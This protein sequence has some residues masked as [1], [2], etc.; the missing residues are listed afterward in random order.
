MAE[1]VKLLADIGANA[2][3]FS[4]EWSRVEPADGQWD[5]TAWEHYGGEI[6]QLRRANIVP[7]V[8]L[9]QGPG[10]L[11]DSGVEIYPEGLLRL[12]RRVWDRY[13]LPIIVTENGVSDASGRL[14]P[15][16]L[17]GHAHAVA[18]AVGEGIPVD[19]YFHWS[20]LDN[21]EWSEGYG[22]SFGL[23][24]VD[25]ETF[26]RRK[27]SGAAEFARLSGLLIRIQETAPK[28]TG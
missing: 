2:Y 5:E 23:Y 15:A 1:D 13:E 19:G 8:T 11:S 17:R 14:R 7:M 18:Q 6:A 16:Y 3:R 22:H 28:G 21:F 25:F 24:T 9:L 4:I 26:E 12:I 27:G 10:P 20:L